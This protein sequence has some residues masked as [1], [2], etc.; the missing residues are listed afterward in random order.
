MNIGIIGTGRIAKRFVPECFAVPGAEITAVYNPHAESAERFVEQAFQKSASGVPAALDHIGNIWN[1]VDAVYI[2]SP[3][4]THIDYVKAALEHGKHVLCEKPLAFLKHDAE[5]VFALAADCGLVLLEGLKTAY[6][7]GYQKLIETAKSGIIG[8]IR[9]IDACFTKLESPESRE[10]TDRVYG[11]SFLELGSYVLLPVFDLLGAA[12]QHL[13]FD[14]LI[15]ETGSDDTRPD[16]Y[17]A[18]GIDLFTK[19]AFR[20]ENAMATLVCGLGV[21]SEGRLVMGGTKGYIVVPAPWWKTTR[22]E[23]HFE[24][25]SD[26]RVFEE[27]FEG[28]GLRYE[29][30]EFVNRAEMKQ[31]NSASVEVRRSIW[32]AEV[33]ERFYRPD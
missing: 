7:P 8:E 15:G 19:A 4:E 25:P 6:A 9:Y 21:K 28:D 3:H 23:V 1:V 24:N 13:S 10:L 30:R 12:Y 22:F 29:I 16:R 27:P 20:Y 33:M 18:G 17:R 5:D 31:A 32:M 14:S 11:G 26:V 2:A